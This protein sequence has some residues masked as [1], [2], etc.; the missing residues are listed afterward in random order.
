MAPT[1]RRRASSRALDDDAG[2]VRCRN[3][4]YSLWTIQGR[5]CPECG[6]SF[7]PSEFEF[8]RGSVAYRCPHC[9]QD[10]YGTSPQGHLEPRVFDCVRC[11]KRI[12]MDE[13]VLEPTDGMSAGDVGTLAKPNPWTARGSSNIV[14]AWFRSLGKILVEPHTFGQTL[15]LG[16]PTSEAIKFCSISIGV[17]MLLTLLC[18]TPG[19]IMMLSLGAGGPAG[20]LTALPAGAPKGLMLWSIV[21][22]LLAPLVY[23]DI[24]VPVMVAWMYGV[25]RAG[26]VETTFGR[27]SQAAIYSEGAASLL[28]AIPCVNAIA[29]LW[30]AVSA[31]MM[32]QRM[33]RC[34]G[35]L[36]AVATIP[37]VGLALVLSLFL[38][39]TPMVG[40]MGPMSIATLL[41]T[42]VGRGG[43]T[44]TSTFVTGPAGEIGVGLAQAIES[45][46]GTS[47][48][49][50]LTPLD[51][52]A[53]G[54][55]DGVILLQAIAPDG[56]TA[57]VGETPQSEIMFGAGVQ[58]VRDESARLLTKLPSGNAPFRLGAAVFCYRG[59]TASA[60]H[61]QAGTLT[62][63]GTQSRIGGE[64]PWLV[65]V[66][67]RDTSGAVMIATADGARWT[68]LAL[69][70]DQLA[71][72]NELR[73]TLGLP[74]L[75]N[76]MTVPDIYTGIVPVIPE[77]VDGVP[78]FSP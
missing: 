7:L 14:A 8:R 29:R 42:L 27:T 73:S 52:V 51:A 10:Y 1:T 57:G 60:L 16:A 44:S 39:V 41:G 58:S 70:P 66:L 19:I 72:Q 28:G 77:E 59:V 38:A 35:W 78:S 61:S 47:D 54:D 67:P 31:T 74:P 9:R 64:L 15:P 13:M 65:V 23:R 5:S 55:L 4:D 62:G 22:P 63:S 69:L 32:L 48:W 71:A 21:W 46:D 25:M 45:A 30:W 6:V 40:M 50:N 37:G 18:S 36:A 68:N 49:A 3:C 75:P 43:V 34:N 56:T 11:N 53:N 26:R 33:H 17:E 12:S 24:F 2:V 20:A 76:L